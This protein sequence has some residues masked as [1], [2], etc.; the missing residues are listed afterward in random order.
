MVSSEYSMHSFTMRFKPKMCQFNDRNIFLN[1]FRIAFMI[2]DF[3]DLC[4]G[5]TNEPNGYNA[6]AVRL[7]TK[8]GYR[9]LNIPHTE[10]STSD[11]LLQRVQY[12]DTKL[13][14]IVKNK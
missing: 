12:L 3:H 11:K 14:E 9:V 1:N 8:N 13:K 5:Q 4:K 6:L 10:F 7:L 2:F